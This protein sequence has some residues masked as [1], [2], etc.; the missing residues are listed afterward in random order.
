MKTERINKKVNSRKMEKN[1]LLAKPRM[2]RGSEQRKCLFEGR[3]NGVPD[4]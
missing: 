1:S 2:A 3:L 4:L